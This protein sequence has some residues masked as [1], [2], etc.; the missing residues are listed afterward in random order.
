[1]TGKSPWLQ[2]VFFEGPPELAGQIVPVRITGVTGN[3]LAGSQ[4]HDAGR[5]S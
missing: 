5:A 4:E 1:M 3:S 2:P